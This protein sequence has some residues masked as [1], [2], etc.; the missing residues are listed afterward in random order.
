MTTEMQSTD[1]DKEKRRKGDAISGGILLI[2]L[3]V[4]LFTGWW[5]PG[6]MFVVGLSSGAGL[7]FRGKTAQGVGTLALLWSIPIGIWIIQE[8][9][10]HWSLVGPMILIGVGIIVLVKAFFLRDKPI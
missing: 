3:G 6:I 9:E 5:W 1:M 2:G 10:I 4:L 7:I 8:A